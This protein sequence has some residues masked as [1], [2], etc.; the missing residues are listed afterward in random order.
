[1]SNPWPPYYGHPAVRFGLGWRYVTAQELAALQKTNT[2]TKKHMKR[3]DYFPTRTTAQIPWLEN[4]REKIA[5][6]TATLGLNATKVAD[7]VA[8]ARFVVYILSQ[9]LPAVRAFGPA[10]TQAMEEA[11]TGTGVAPVV[12]PTF[13]APALPTT[14]TPA[15]VPVPPGALNRIFD[16]V[17]E[18]KEADGYT[19]AIGE[20]LGVIGAEDTSVHLSPVMELK[21]L[22]GAPCQCVEVRFVKYGHMGVYIESRRN[23]GAWEFLAIDTESPYTDERPLLVAGAPEI[24]EYRARFWDKGEANGEWTDVARVT[25]AP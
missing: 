14:P 24:R 9:W 1:M 21:V 3:Q 22:Q 6:Y 2:K 23:G 8:S 11:L 13:T 4:F 10:C 15:V 5:G 7:A 17:E 20:D 12:L 16:L 25:V 19:T 18:L